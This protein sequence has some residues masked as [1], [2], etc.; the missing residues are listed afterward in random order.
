MFRRL[1]IAALASLSFVSGRAVAAVLT[2]D[3]LSVVSLAWSPD[4]TT[5]AY[6]LS[7]ANGHSQLARVPA[8]GGA[9]TILTPADDYS[10]PTWNAQSNQLLTSR[11]APDGHR[12]VC[13]VSAIDGSILYEDTHPDRMAPVFG[14][15]R[16][17]GDIYA[18]ARSG[19]TLQR[20]VRINL[21]A[22]TET[23]LTV[24]GP[25]QFFPRWCPGRQAVVADVTPFGFLQLFEPANLS[26]A[27]SFVRADYLTANGPFDLSI[28]DLNSDG[29]PD[30]VAADYV[31]NVISVLLGNGSG[32]FGPK[33]D[34][35]TAANPSGVAIGDINS[36]G[37]L[38]L[39][40]SSWS[41]NAVSLFIGNGSGGFGPR[42]DIPAGFRAISP[43]L[44]DLNGDG[45]LDLILALRSSKTI[46]VQ[47]ADGLGGFGEADSYLTPGFPYSIAVGDLNADGHPD[48]VV[49]YDAGAAVVSVFLGDGSGVFGAP[50]NFAVGSVPRSVAVDDVNRDGKPDIA[51]VDQ[52]T[53]L[54]SVLLG[55]GDGTFETRRDFATGASPAWTA[56]ADVNAD[57]LPD[58][59][60]TNSGGA[61]ESVLLGDGAGG[62]AP[63]VDI[64]TGASPSGVRVG[65]LNADGRNDILVAD[66]GASSVSV[67]LNNTSSTG[68]QLTN[69]D[70]CDVIPAD[71]D[72][73]TGAILFQAQVDTPDSTWDQILYVDASNTVHQVTTEPLDHADPAWSPDGSH[74]TFMRQ[75]A[76]GVNIYSIPKSG[77]SEIPVTLGNGIRR[78]GR[79]SPSGAHVAYLELA[80]TS[81][82]GYWQLAVTSL[83]AAGV[84]TPR[85]PLALHVRSNPIS[86]NGSVDIDYT[87][88]V[89]GH[90][91]LRVYDSSGRLVRVL[92][93]AN[94]GAGSHSA[95]WAPRSK[96]GSSTAGIYF[97]AL[98]AEGSRH[99]A[100]LVVLR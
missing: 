14:S 27:M 18:D 5:L 56:I 84:A 70:S 89:S 80:N 78:F 25:A 10:A 79:I 4:G 1:L 92:L 43:K 54:V 85:E 36:D 31:S 68:T 96:Q 66:F 16:D 28:A 26:S 30:V 29:R 50:S 63:K 75:D 82:G 59:V 11:I 35:G 87:L 74:I 64:A 65:D 76:G 42:T 81:S 37:I 3:T 13:I 88:P 83:P 46:T 91:R 72:P 7:N 40:V 38:D 17:A 41:E 39:A 67:L 100:R 58:L 9:V 22:G 44:V 45:K 53:N 33:T 61:S 32:G 6:S 47:L 19:D 69:A 48:L 51:V 15:G 8:S 20:V 90:V 34:F 94:V 73:A 24:P 49:G 77:G 57:A 99:S 21:V 2:P 55:H 62:F 93:D 98:D 86:A 95:R 97:V 71:V 60:V 52:A 12:H 23:A